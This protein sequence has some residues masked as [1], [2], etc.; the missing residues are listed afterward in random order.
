MLRKRNSAILRRLTFFLCATLSQI[1]QVLGLTISGGCGL[2]LLGNYGVEGDFSN[3]DEEQIFISITSIGA[4]SLFV[5]AVWKGLVIRGEIKHDEQNAATGVGEEQGPTQEDA[6]VQDP[7]VTELATAFVGLGVLATTVQ[8]G[9]VIA[10]ITTT[11]TVSTDYKTAASAFLPIAVVLYLISLFAQPRR[12]DRRSMLFLRAH[13]ISFTWVS[14]GAYIYEIRSDSR[15]TITGI[16]HLG[17]ALLETL[18]FHYGLKLRASIGCLPDNDLNNFLVEILFKGSFKTLSSVLFILFRSLKCVLERGMG[19]CTN[20]TEC[21]TWISVM[22]IFAWGLKLGQGSIKSEWRKQLSI[23]M[24]KVSRMKISWR[25]AAVGLLLAVM[26]GCGAF[27][28]ALTSAKEI[29]GSLVLALGLIGLLAGAACFVSEIYAMTKERTRRRRGQSQLEQPDNVSREE[30]VENCSWWYVAVSLVITTTYTVLWITY[31]ITLADWTCQ[32]ATLLLPIADTCMIL[33]VMLKPKDDGAGLKILH[34]QFFFFALGRD[35][36]KAVGR[37]RG[38]DTTEG[39]Y[40]LVRI[41]FWLGAYWLFLKL[42]RKAAQLPPAKL[43]SFLCHT[44]L[45]GGMSAMAPM[46][47]FMFEAVSC[48]ASG[49]GLHDDQCENTTKAATALSCYLAIITAVSVAS[50]TVPQDERVQGMTYSNLVILRLKTREKVQGALGLVTALVSM[51]LFSVLG[52]GGEPS[53]EIYVL[54]LIGAVAL[55]V[56]AMIEFTT[57][58]FGRS[59]STTGDGQAGTSPGSLTQQSNVS[60]ESRLSLRDVE[61][62]MTIMGML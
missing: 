33:A 28:F 20:N 25:Q 12:H 53:G 51:Y 2:F 56:V 57:L 24:E 45:L 23:S 50:R 36:A 54:G 42:R 35:V 41:P 4:A 9:L 14:E 15:S 46:V 44:V 27:L 22:L 21:A 5:T 1:V 8:V 43:S 7:P 31:A 39:W 30:L 19:S 62:N 6:Q 26:A 59:V 13:F 47:F 58:A 49:G 55:G 3:N 52:V 10:E 38:I 29:D 34:I 40:A 32:V 37:F 16:Y 61:E 18:V 48:M 17:R 60:A 11:S